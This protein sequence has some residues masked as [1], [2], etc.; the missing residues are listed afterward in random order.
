MPKTLKDFLNF[1]LF[2]HATCNLI[3][4]VL[5]KLAYELTLTFSGHN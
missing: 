2:G 4:T 1:A 5:V 3:F